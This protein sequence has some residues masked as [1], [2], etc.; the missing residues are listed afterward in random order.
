M[1]F[2]SCAV[3]VDRVLNLW[4]VNCWTN[5]LNHHTDLIGHVNVFKYQPISLQFS[6]QSVEQTIRFSLGVVY[7]SLGISITI[8][9]NSNVYMPYYGSQLLSL[10]Y[11]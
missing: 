6:C 9:D 10:A 3:A 11:L 1:R 5:A 4:S 2:S 8:E 7:V